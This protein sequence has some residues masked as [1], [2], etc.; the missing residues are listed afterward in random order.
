MAN[1]RKAFNGATEKDVFDAVL[2]S[3]PLG[4]RWGRTL[5]PFYR[6]LARCL[7]KDPSQRP[8]NGQAL[9][10]ELI[11]IG[12]GQTL[13]FRFALIAALL[14]VSLFLAQ[15]VDRIRNTPRNGFEA[16]TMG[17]GPHQYMDDRTRNAVQGVSPSKERCPRR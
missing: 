4:D 3:D 8:R 17:W 2:Y 9:V 11:R 13:R 6:F 12:R 14:L 7:S 10:D 15:L 16:G 1:G 5:S